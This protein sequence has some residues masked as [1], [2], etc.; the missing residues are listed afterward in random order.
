MKLQKGEQTNL[1]VKS[2]INIKFPFNLENRF[3]FEK[4]SSSVNLF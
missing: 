2:L 1:K 3:V 4:L